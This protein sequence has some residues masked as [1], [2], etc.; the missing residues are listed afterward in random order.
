MRR[1]RPIAVLTK[2]NSN[3]ELESFMINSVYAKEGFTLSSK[4]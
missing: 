2:G 4:V 3:D 1:G